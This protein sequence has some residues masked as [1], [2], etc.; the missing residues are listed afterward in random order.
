MEKLEHTISI[1]LPDLTKQGYDLLTKEQKKVLH[2]RI[3]LSVAEA[4]H[5]ARFNPIEYLGD[6]A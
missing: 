4:I 5:M 3:R 2:H 1:K 6:E